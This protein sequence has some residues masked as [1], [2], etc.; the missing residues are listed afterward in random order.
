MGWR[1]CHLFMCIVTP[2]LESLMGSVQSGNLMILACMEGSH[3][4]RAEGIGENIKF[5]ALC[6]TRLDCRTC[7]PAGGIAQILSL[8]QDLDVK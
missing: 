2:T 3:D 1:F 6:P 5:G 8:L 7:F 4:C